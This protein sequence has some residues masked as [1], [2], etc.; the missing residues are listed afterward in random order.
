MKDLVEF[1]NQEVL[2]C[3]SRKTNRT[4]SR[5]LQGKQ[6]CTKIEVATSDLPIDFSLRGKLLGKGGDNF[7]RICQ[8]TGCSLTVVGDD[9]SQLPLNS[10]ANCGIYIQVR[11]PSIPA[12]ENDVKRFAA[13]S[14]EQRASAQARRDAEK[15]V[16]R[17]RSEQKELQAEAKENRRMVQQL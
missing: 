16:A 15:E 6:Q 12:H 10:E 4:S 7:K 2:F 3:P 5:P 9:Q 14:L 1:V 11:G 17:L 8:G 13:R